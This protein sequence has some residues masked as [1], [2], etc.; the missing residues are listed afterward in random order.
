VPRRYRVK[1][2]GILVSGIY[3]KIGK[4][5]L[6][7]AVFKSKWP[8]SFAHP[9]QRSQSKVH[10]FWDQ[11]CLQGGKKWEDGFIEGLALSVVFVP[12]LC[13]VTLQKWR[14]QPK[15]SDASPQDWFS[16]DSV[17]NFL[18]ECIVALE[19]NARLVLLHH[20]DDVF[21]CKRILPVFVDD[22]RCT[23]SDAAA[24]AT[25]S[26]A[27]DILRSLN[28]LARDCAIERFQRLIAPA[29]P[30]QSLPPP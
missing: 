15:T 25:I 6:D 3:D 16:A 19:L 9:S 24:T 1:A 27:E 4:M 20:A 13:R 23:L 10:V 18:L 30:S 26:K 22:E 7:R 2:S 12:V 8:C 29:L 11:L 21:A 5:A 17:D 14:E 28:V